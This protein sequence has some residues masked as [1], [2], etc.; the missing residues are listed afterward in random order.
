MSAYV[1]S[2]SVPRVPAIANLVIGEGLIEGGRRA[3]VV[4][5][6]VSRRQPN[7]CVPIDRAGVDVWY[8]TTASLYCSGRWGYSGKPKC[9]ASTTQS[10]LSRPLVDCEVAPAACTRIPISCNRRAVWSESHG[11]IQASI[12]QTRRAPPLKR[13]TPAWQPGPALHQPRKC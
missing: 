1:P 13:P 12:L 4:H 5:V 3:P 10:Q 7:Q 2:C 9:C 8:W 11:V 6:R